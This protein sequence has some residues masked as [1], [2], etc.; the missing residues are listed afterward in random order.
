MF[1]ISGDRA[2]SFVMVT[3]LVG[4]SICGLRKRQAD[5]QRSREVLAACEIAHQVT[6]SEQEDR[7]RLG[8]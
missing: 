8:A 2:V 6:S 1:R 3:A 5:E 7:Y 4:L